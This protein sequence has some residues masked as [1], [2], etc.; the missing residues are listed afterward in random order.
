MYWGSSKDPDPAGKLQ[1]PPARFG[2]SILLPSDPS[3]TTCKCYAV[4]PPSAGFLQ[5]PS[6]KFLLHSAGACFTGPN[7][8][9]KAAEKP[10]GALLEM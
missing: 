8:Q 6:S 7:L 3:A 1:R 2:A 9:A 10:H 4:M 5:A